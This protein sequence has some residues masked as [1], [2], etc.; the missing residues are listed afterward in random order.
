MVRTM[1]QLTE[2]QVKDLKKLA[3]I[4]KISVA[5]L[6]RESVSLYV[7]TSKANIKEDEKRRRALEGL[8]KI[9]KAKYKDI[10]GKKDLSTNH[11]YYL[12][13]AYAS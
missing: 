2:G 4:R 6:V 5:A 10:E 1:I 13:E 3:K 9:R 12:E 11:D 8:E 7:N